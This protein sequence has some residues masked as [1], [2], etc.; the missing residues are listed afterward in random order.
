MSTDLLSFEHPSVLLF[1][2]RSFSE[3]KMYYNFVLRIRFESNLSSG[4]RWSS[5]Q[6]KSVKAPW[7]L[8]RS[9]IVKRIWRRQNDSLN[10]VRTIGLVF[11]PSTTLYRLSLNHINL[12]NKPL[13]TIWRILSKPLQIRPVNRLPKTVDGCS[14]RQLSAWSRSKLCYRTFCWRFCIVRI[15]CWYWGFYQ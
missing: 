13:G 3:L 7:M 10:I 12:T 6:I 8:F 2:F 1:C 14:L 11:D 9:K 4:L 5:V 15:C